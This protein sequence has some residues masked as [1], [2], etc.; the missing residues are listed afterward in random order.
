MARGSPHRSNRP[1]AAVFL[2]QGNCVSAK[3]QEKFDQVTVL[4]G[5]PD[6]D[7]S[8]LDILDH[9]LNA[10]VVVQGSVVISLAGVDLLYVGL[11]A[12]LTS[13]QTA[14]KHIDFKELPPARPRKPAP[15]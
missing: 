5:N 15:R 6:S 9:V 10:G 3:Q 1:L 13:V 7:L 8:L 11:S 12:V 2:R 14:L 4:G